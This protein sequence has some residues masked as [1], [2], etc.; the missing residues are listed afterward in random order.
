M[1]LERMYLIP[2]GLSPESC[3][4]SA[5]FPLRQRSFVHRVIELIS[6]Q[7]GR[8]GCVAFEYTKEARALL[9]GGKESRR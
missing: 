2:L 8:H 9:S 6:L 7:V 1:V 3:K 4:L 5:W